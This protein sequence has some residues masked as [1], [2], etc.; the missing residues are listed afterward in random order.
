MMSLGPLL[1]NTGIRAGRNATKHPGLDENSSPKQIMDC[2]VTEESVEKTS[3]KKRKTQGNSK[4]N[5]KSSMNKYAEPKQR[6]ERQLRKAQPWRETSAA[7]IRVVFAMIVLKRIV[8]KPNLKSY[9]STNRSTDTP[10]FADGMALDKVLFIL[11]S[12]PSTKTM[13][14]KMTGSRR[15]DRFWTS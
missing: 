4:E 10:Y 7:E 1:Q 9:L 11:I 2:F 14:T 8:S 3:N 12:I 13:K 15:S 5:L 6:D